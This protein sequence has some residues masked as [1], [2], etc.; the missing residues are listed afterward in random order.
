V[1]RVLV[2]DEGRIVEDVP[3]AQMSSAAA[4]LAGV[5]AGGE[6]AQGGV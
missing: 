1:D 4:L 2:M 3:P 6:T 5:R